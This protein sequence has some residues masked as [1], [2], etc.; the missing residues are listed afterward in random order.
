M[1]CM[2]KYSST[3]T[4]ACFDTPVRGIVSLENS[5]VNLAV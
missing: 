1:I 4:P 2:D 3:H 5:E